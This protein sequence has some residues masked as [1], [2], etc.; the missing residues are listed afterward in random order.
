M[1]FPLLVLSVS[2]GSLLHPS[3]QNKEDTS[4]EGLLCAN[5][6]VSHFAINPHKNLLKYPGAYLINEALAVYILQKLSKE[7]FCL[8]EIGQ[9][10]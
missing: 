8:T 2:Q 10:K 5:Q 9:T 3:L 6:C 7:S 1:V 4:I